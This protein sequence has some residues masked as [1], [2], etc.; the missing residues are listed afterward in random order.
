MRKVRCLYDSGQ[1]ICPKKVFDIWQYNVNM[2]DL[3]AC[4]AIDLKYDILNF[5]GGFLCWM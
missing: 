4:M 2:K 3:L 1:D 5:I